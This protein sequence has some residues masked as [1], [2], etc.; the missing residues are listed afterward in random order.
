MHNHS[1]VLRRGTG[2]LYGLIL[3]L[4]LGEAVY[5]WAQTKLDVLSAEH[6][7]ENLA[8]LKREWK[9]GE[10][11]TLLIS[12]VPTQRAYA[13]EFSPKRL[14]EEATFV[15]TVRGPNDQELGNEVMSKLE[16]LAVKSIAEK[17]AV[18]WSFVFLNGKGD[19]IFS[20]YLNR[21]G[22]CGYIDDS[23]VSFES[24]DLFLWAEAKL[25]KTLR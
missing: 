13:L 22:L 1:I 19:R 5:A 3:A 14:D 11:K 15:I 9:N 12:H 8:R 25:G 7:E 23:S 2:F 16:R 20:L 21:T 6:E 24:D 17:P 18:R 10:V 4:G